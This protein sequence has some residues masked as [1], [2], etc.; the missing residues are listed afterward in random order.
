MLTGKNK[1]E[2][3]I[4]GKAT[5]PGRAPRSSDNLKD[6]MIQSMRDSAEIV[7]AAPELGFRAEDAGRLGSI[8][9][10]PAHY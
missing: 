3:L 1:V 2:V 8:C 10:W 5:E 6:V 7:A 4:L 9:L